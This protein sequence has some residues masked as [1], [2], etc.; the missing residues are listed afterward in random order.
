[1]I[2]NQER[3]DEEKETLGPPIKIEKSE[4]IENN[5]ESSQ[6]LGEPTVKK[7][8]EGEQSIKIDKKK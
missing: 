6:E 7:Y 1:M 5:G 4:K 3:E 8:G 2:Q